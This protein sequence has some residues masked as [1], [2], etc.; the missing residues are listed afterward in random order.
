[1]KI[2][3]VLAALA[4][5]VSLVKGYSDEDAWRDYQMEQI[6]RHNSKKDNGFFQELN[7]FSV[8][9]RFQVMIKS[10]RSTYVHSNNRL[11]ARW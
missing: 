8:L 5:A 11:I 10:I 6:K 1:M 4:M 2:F 3:F 9:V 7:E